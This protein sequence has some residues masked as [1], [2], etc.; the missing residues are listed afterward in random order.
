M[1]LILRSPFPFHSDKYEHGSLWKFEQ[2]YEIVF[3]W[4]LK[5]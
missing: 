3:G 1:E 2:I 4:Y 5:Y